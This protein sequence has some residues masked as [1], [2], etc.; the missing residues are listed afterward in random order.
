MRKAA[1]LCDAHCFCGTTPKLPSKGLIPTG[2]CVKQSCANPG[3]D[4]RSPRGPGQCLILLLQFPL[5]PATRAEVFPSFPTPA[6]HAGCRFRRAL[7]EHPHLLLC[8]A[9]PPASH[10]PPLCP[11]RASLPASPAPSFQQGNV[12]PCYPHRQLAACRLSLVIQKQQESS[13][14]SSTR[15]AGQG[16]WLPSP[17]VL[18]KSCMG[19][20]WR[21]AGME[22]ASPPPWP[23]WNIPF[24]F[25]KRQR[26]FSFCSRFA[27][28]NKSARERL[29]PRSRHSASHTFQQLKYFLD[30]NVIQKGVRE[31]GGG[32]IAS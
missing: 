22:A 8:L 18:L 4:L 10:S 13:F 32:G 23:W 1:V 29:I 11:H 25:P 27:F 19:R 17:P 2:S 15:A 14:A 12:I 3:T 5:M 7:C 28:M 31:T 21:R 30:G 9:G 16:F 20:G 6:L 24:P 26:G